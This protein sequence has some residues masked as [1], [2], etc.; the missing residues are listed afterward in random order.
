MTAGFGARR[1]QDGIVIEIPTD[2]V[3]EGAADTVHFLRVTLVAPEDVGR[4]CTVAAKGINNKSVHRNS[5]LLVRSDTGEVV[6][7]NVE[8]APYVRTR[9]AKRLTIGTEISAAVRLGR[10]GVFS[11]G[12]VVELSDCVPPPVEIPAE[13]IAF[14]GHGKV[15]DKYMNEIELTT[16]LITEIQDSMIDEILK[17]EDITVDSTVEEAQKLLASQ[18]LNI[19]ETILIK[20][21]MINKLLQE[22][23]RPLLI[24]KYVWRNSALSSHYLA[25]HPGLIE[26]LRPEILD[27][28]ERLGFF[29]PVTVTRVLPI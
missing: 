12:L 23:P 29:K 21:G 17:A 15:F 26:Q 25:L 5:D 8:R 28:L 1:S 27:L 18:A 7:A 22:N 14:A 10:D 6:L 13:K 9:A 20:S 19:D 3:I 16:S 24:T 2:I 11:G 4:E